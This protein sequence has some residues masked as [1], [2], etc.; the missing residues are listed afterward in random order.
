MR[1]FPV[2]FLALSGCLLGPNQGQVL[3]GANASVS[4]WGYSNAPNQTVYLQSATSRD[5]RFT[6]FSQVVTAANPTQYAG[7][8]IY[9]FSKNVTIPQWNST[10]AQ[11]RTYVRAVIYPTGSFQSPSYLT[12]YDINPPVGGT[13]AGCINN[14]VSAGSTLNQAIA[15]CASDDSPVAELTAPALSTCPC[16]NTTYT[17]NL[18]IDDALDAAQYVC[19]QTL[20][21]NLTVAE[22]APENVPFP[23]L[24]SVSGN[25]SL[26]H[27]R[28]YQ[29]NGNT[30]YNTRL[31]D[32]PV[33]AHIGGNLSAQARTNEGVAGVPAGLHAVNQVGGDI[34]IQLRGTHPNYLSALTHLDGNLTIESY[35]SELDLNGGSTLAS[36]NTVGGDVTVRN[37]YN[38]NGV[39]N[40]LDSINGSLT[41]QNFRLQGNCFSQL[42]S[43]GG[44]FHLNSMKD[45]G[46]FAPDLETVGGE[47]GYLGHN[48][49]TTLSE[50][51]WALTAQAL[52]IENNAALT[53]LTGIQAQITSGPIT[54]GG[55]PQLSQ[56][57]VNT[58]LADQTSGGWT[59]VANIS[60]TLPCP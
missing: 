23:Q 13:A 7:A 42:V 17:G 14:R 40:G 31:I 21:G 59:G 46:I 29:Q 11:L 28:P 34:L 15:Y 54:I 55:S 49:V 4:F 10:D 2:L 30:L 44:N 20:T 43:V 45:V 53:A 26:N 37:F 32:L 3:C 33:L 57:L 58:F 24:T 51:P 48:L 22:T 12:T 9:H 8:Q 39:L 56:C 25:V 36:L 5:G 35:G 1:L 41:L 50:V 6:T 18:V 38:T 19:L 47:L 52:R 27:G 16:T 60:G